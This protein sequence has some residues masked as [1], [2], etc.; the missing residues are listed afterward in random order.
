LTRMG[1]SLAHEG[2][3][4]TMD[5]SVTIKCAF[6][7][8]DHDSFRRALAHLLEREPDIEIV[9]QAGSLQEARDVTTVDLL[10]PD[11]IGTDFIREVHRARPELPVL[12]VT[13]VREKEVHDWA[14]AMGATEVMTKDVAPEE[15]VAAVRRLAL[16][17]DG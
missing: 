4:A 12:V 7:L 10:L 8:E 13:L 1:V 5:E 11:G 16:A 14:R 6:L 2:I 3:K 15:I 9:G 17:G